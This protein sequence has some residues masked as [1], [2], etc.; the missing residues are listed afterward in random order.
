MSRHLAL[1]V[2]ADI[3]LGDFAT[4]AGEVIVDARMRCRIYGD[5]ELGSANGWILVFHALT[6]SHDVHQWWGPLLG[7]GLALDT[8]SHPVIAAN[9]LG[10]CYGSSG[11]L[12]GIPFPAL[13]PGDLAG[14]HNLLPGA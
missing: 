10:S 12:P 4:E 5:P 9:L 1:P 6:G 13:S 3:A 11:P 8:T 14:A 7:D 2:Q